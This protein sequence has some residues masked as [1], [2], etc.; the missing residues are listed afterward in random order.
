MR[1]AISLLSSATIEALAVIELAE[2]T[3]DEAMAV[4]QLVGIPGQYLCS[5]TWHI[6][7]FS[8]SEEVEIV[9]VQPSQWCLGVPE[10]LEALT[11][12]VAAVAA[13]AA[14]FF[15]DRSFLGGIFTQLTRLS[16]KQVSIY[17]SK[18][19]LHFRMS[20]RLPINE[21]SPVK[22]VWLRSLTVYDSLFC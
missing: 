6:E 21:C 14:C 13:V 18:L 17:Y 15:T 7:Q 11:L 16:S 2:N 8:A 5:H 19:G 20:V 12:E 10:A 3:K 9:S 1:A 22:W 4:S